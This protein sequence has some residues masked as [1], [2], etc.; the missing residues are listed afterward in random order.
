MAS[1]GVLGSLISQLGAR[2]MPQYDPQQVALTQQRLQSGRLGNETAL[3]QLAEL[4]RQQASDAEVMQFMQQHPELVLGGGQGQPTPLLGSLTAGAPPGG[5][6]GAITQSPLGGGPVQTVPAYP[7][8]SRY[9]VVSPQSGGPIPPEVAA[10]LTP[11]VTPPQGTLASLGPQPQAPQNPLLDLV[12]R[13]PRAAFM[14]FQKQHEMM[15]QRLKMGTA[16]AEGIGQIILG[17]K[18]QADLD[19]ARQRIAQFAPQEAARLP[20]AYSP[21]AM[22]PYL[23]RAVSV[24]DSADLKLK[25]W[26]M[27]NEERKNQLEEM[28]IGVQLTNA[29]YQGLGTDVTSILR[30]LTDEQVKQFGGRTTPAAVAYATEEEKKRKLHQAGETERQRGETERTLRGEKTVSEAM[31][32][33]AT[34]LFDIQTGQTLDARMKV[35]DYDALPAGSVK[36]LSPK[37]TEQMENINNAVPVLSQLQTHIDKIYGP[38]GVL[39][40]MSPDERTLL[41]NAPSQW[42][43]QYAQKYPE[44]IQAQRFIDSNAGSLARALAGEKGAMAEGDVE[45]AKAMLPTLTTALKVWP[46]TEL[47]WTQPDTREVALRSMNSIVDLVNGRVRTLLGNEQFTHPKLHRYE[48]SE[49]DP[50]RPIPP[51]VGLNPNLPPVSGQ[52]PQPVAPVPPPGPPIFPRPEI[53]EPGALPPGKQSQAP[54][55]RRGIELARASGAK[56]MDMVDVE[57]AMDETGKSRAEVLAAA[58]AKGYTVYGSAM[59]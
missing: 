5:A 3:L 21:E 52:G 2:E 57:Q 58:R 8:A 15:G 19:E 40:R 29:G 33:K 39:A 4:K 53:R 10:Q 26:N 34:N 56:V 45:R 37:L 55:G 31:G 11:T 6:S 35:K 18:S 42:A 22:K 48:V 9:A 41:T 27:Q 54:S 7:D 12:R 50:D 47:G 43:K 49:A 44:L 38:G 46:P 51:L 24:K 16:V 28:K 36:E 14:F 1:I 20:Q 17:V 25:T 30:G 32:T 23:D 59:A 13:D